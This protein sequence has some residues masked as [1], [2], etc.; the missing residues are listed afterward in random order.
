ML[1][2]NG[3]KL[4]V[5]ENEMIES[6]FESGGTCVGYYKVNKKTISILNLQKEKIGIITHRGVMGKATKQENG[7]YWYS[8]GMPENIGEY[9]SY[10]QYVEEVER[11][12]KINNIA[13]KR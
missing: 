10:M 11:A 5:N 8:Y 4:A 1:I 7:G 3:K 13:I 9:D 12:L 2:L 6:L